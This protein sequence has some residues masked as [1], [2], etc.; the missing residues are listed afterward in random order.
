MSSTAVAA[1]KKN[2]HSLV[3]RMPEEKLTI[4]VQLMRSFDE[5]ERQDDMQARRAAFQR[6]ESMIK[7]VPGLD[8]KKE[9]ASWREEKFGNAGA[10]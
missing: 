1:L 10:D 3:E 6:L 2:A 7:H 5:Q 9:L 8:E 4:L